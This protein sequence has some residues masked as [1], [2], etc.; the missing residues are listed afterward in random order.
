MVPALIPK[1]CRIFLNVFTAAGM[2]WEAESELVSPLP[3][4]SLN[5]RTEQ[6]LLTIC[7]MAVHVSREGYTVTEMSLS[8]AILYTRQIVQQKGI[9]NVEIL[10]CENVTKVYGSGNSQVWP[11]IISTFRCK[12][13]NLWPLW[14][15]PDQENQ[16]C[17]IF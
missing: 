15:H 5:C 12:K 17:C 14:G 9:A 2:P 16:L 1:T 4:P 10:R 11:W 6:L 3:A 8:F 7:K 13:E